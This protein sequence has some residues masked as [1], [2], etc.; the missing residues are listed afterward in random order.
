M[1]KVLWHVT[2]S[3]DGFIAGPGD[4]MDWVLESLEPA[5][6]PNPV[7]EEVIQTTGAMLAGRRSYD[8]AAREDQGAY[9]GAWTGPQFVL[10]HEPPKEPPEDP[11]ITFLTGDVREA[12]ATALAAAGGKNVVVA[13]ADVARQCLE[14]GLVDEILVHIVPVLLGDGV[15]FY[16]NAG[17]ERVTLEPLTVARTGR[18]TNLRFRVVGSPGYREERLWVELSGT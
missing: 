1:A 14:E 11:L 13:G 17:A 15:R 6:E 2:M 16:E 7:V 8:V 9:G 12:V 10:T 5:P 3:L 4:G 18:L